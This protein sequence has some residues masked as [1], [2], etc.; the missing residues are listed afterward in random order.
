MNTDYT[1]KKPCRLKGEKS[2]LSVEIRVPILK[3]PGGQKIH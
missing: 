1:V 2:V 3:A